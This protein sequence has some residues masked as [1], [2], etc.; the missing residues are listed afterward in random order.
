MTST[1]RTVVSRRGQTVV[2]A[3]I[4]HRHQIEEG[5]TLIWMDDG[6]VIKVYPLPDDAVT[7]LR[8]SG[9][10]EHLLERLLAE[11][12]RDQRRRS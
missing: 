2:P 11:R 3:S 10:G 12:Q 1:I 9:K 8:G 6:R 7:T 4:R 5:D